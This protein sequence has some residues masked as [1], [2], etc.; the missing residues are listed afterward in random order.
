MLVIIL[1]GSCHDKHGEEPRAHN[2]GCSV[3]IALRFRTLA[4]GFCYTCLD[5]DELEKKKFRVRILEGQENKIQGN[6]AKHVEWAGRSPLV[7]QSRKIR[8]CQFFPPT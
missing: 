1:E 6:R 2:V 5:A 8:I 7:C 4:C 3:L